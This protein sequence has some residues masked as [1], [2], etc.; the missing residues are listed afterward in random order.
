MNPS[1][2]VGTLA[3]PFRKKDSIK[4]SE[5]NAIWL[6]LF[7]YEKPKKTLVVELNIKI[8]SDGVSST[9]FL[10]SLFLYACIGSYW[11]MLRNEENQSRADE[12]RDGTFRRYLVPISGSLR[13]T[14]SQQS[15]FEWPQLGVQKAGTWTWQI[16]IRR[17]ISRRVLERRSIKLDGGLPT[18]FK[19][20]FH[21]VNDFQTL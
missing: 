16:S 1:V 21:E 13:C 5:E 6:P 20:I 2:G 18:N 9:N 19:L 3:Q 17:R 11:L 12:K 7:R 10:R 14:R 15:T 8:Y 4:S